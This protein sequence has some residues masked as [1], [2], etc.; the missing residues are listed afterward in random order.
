MTRAILSWFIA[1][2]MLPAAVAGATPVA[3][4]FEHV[5]PVTGASG[6]SRILRDS[7]FEVREASALGV[8]NL[9]QVDIVVLG[10][11]LSERPDYASFV[12]A[13]TAALQ[14]WVRGGGVLLQ[15][16]AAHRKEPIPSF[17]PATH[18]VQ[19]EDDD[20]DELHV[21]RVSHRLVA[22]AVESAGARQLRLPRH[23]DFPVSWNTLYRQAGFNVIL[24][25]DALGTGAALLEGEHGRGRFLLTSLALDKLYRGDV[26]V[27]APEY[28]AFA[29][30]F[31]QNLRGYVESVRLGLAAG[32]SV[33]PSVD[34][35]TPGSRAIVVL[36]DT[37]N[38]VDSVNP[39]RPELFTAQ[40]EWVARQ[41]EALDILFVLHLGDITQ[42]NAPLEWER[43][44][45][46]MNVLDGIVPYSVIGGNHDYG[47]RGSAASRSTLFSDYFPPAK[48]A[49][50]PSFGGTMESGRMEN[51]YHLFDSG[52]DKWLVL[53]LEWAPRHKTVEWGERIIA[54]HPDR[55]VIV[56]THAYLYHDDTRYDWQA[57]GPTQFWSPGLYGTANDPEGWNDGEMLWQKLVSR[58]PNVVLTINGHVLDDGL[59]FLSSAGL[60]GGL[61]HQMLVNFQMRADGGE[62]YLRILELQ[63]DGVTV[64]VRDYSPALD[65]FLLGPQSNF[66]FQLRSHAALT[67]SVEFAPAVPYSV[68]IGSPV[69]LSP[70]VQVSSGEPSWQW[71]RDGVAITGATRRAYVVRSFE[72]ERS[73]TYTLE[74]ALPGG[75]KSR[76]TTR[77]IPAVAPGRL[78][79]ISQRSRT[80]ADQQ[81]VL[82]FSLRGARAAQVLLRGLGPTL[83][84]FG[85]NVPVP[86]P[87]LAVFANDGSVLGLNDDWNELDTGA[88]SAGFGAAAL[89]TGSKDS[90]ILLELTTGT[91]SAACFPGGSDGGTCLIELFHEDSAGEGALEVCNFSTLDRVT[92]ERAVLAFVVTGSGCRTVLVRAVGPTLAQ[93]LLERAIRDPILTVYDAAGRV[94]ANNDD[95]E[96]LADVVPLQDAAAGNGAFA[97]PRG[98]RDAGLM[99][100]LPP[101]AYTV[102]CHDKAHDGGVALLEVYDAN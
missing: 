84:R 63:A 98:S 88:L 37:Q 49:G 96:D 81:A 24:G 92:D 25:T 57:K 82:G 52:G 60:G 48:F 67:Q 30:S 51:N 85:V 47:P 76:W 33:T 93:F 53:C 28:F 73:G 34:S 74:A 32:V 36:P 90:A 77:V 68:P 23:L 35:R 43:A 66:T 102:V 79:N 70:V 50:L 94:V 42:T 41:R 95:W 3:L 26:V 44:R 83:T 14:E 17:L 72:P 61:V 2:V 65:R 13:N 8:V 100:T 7:G 40:T 91:Y 62:G 12:R 5:D 75:G 64:R 87:W 16:T 55:R 97:L 101:G 6:A 78:A 99:V 27:A 18:R 38:Y 9:S 21:L 19:R 59:G 11:F 29:Q 56:V 54:A 46:S 86:D 15:G 80:V 39:S 89:P 1:S 22:K 4:V 71:Y 58:Y 45:G 20:F 31:F 69:V 10:S